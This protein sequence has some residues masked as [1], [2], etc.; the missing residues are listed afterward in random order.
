MSLFI[1]NAMLKLSAFVLFFLVAF[2][3]CTSLYTRINKEPI[4]SSQKLDVEPSDTFVISSISLLDRR[5]DD[6]K[7]RKDFPLKLTNIYGTKNIEKV[8]SFIKQLNKKG[9]KVKTS[10]PIVNDSL[11]FYS[12]QEWTKRIWG[13]K[14]APQNL[15]GNYLI[16]SHNFRGIIG[17]SISGGDHGEIRT[18]YEFVQLSNSEVVGYL[19]YTLVR[20]STLR[21]QLIKYKDVRR[22]F[23]RVL[24]K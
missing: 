17:S 18:L 22:I 23:K 5:C 11:F 15:S 9:V 8:Y 4:I 1:L 21:N 2:S 6:C 19:S 3:S 13:K 14:P 7:W 12:R 16:V 10:G 20:G 24:T